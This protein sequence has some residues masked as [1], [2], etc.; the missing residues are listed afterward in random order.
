MYNIFSKFKK[1]NRTK[2]STTNI[3]RDILEEKIN[4]Y[5]NENSN[6]FLKTLQKHPVKNTEKN[7]PVQSSHGYRSVYFNEKIK[8][9][10]ESL[11][12]KKTPQEK[13]LLID[14]NRNNI[15][16]IM[17]DNNSNNINKDNQV[18]KN[19]KINHESNSYNNNYFNDPNQENPNANSI[20]SQINLQNIS[21][22]NKN[23]N[24]SHIKNNNSSRRNLTQND[25]LLK[26]IYPNEASEKMISESKKILET[27]KEIRSKISKILRSDNACPLCDNF[28]DKVD[29]F[30]RK[31][32]NS[33]KSEFT[34]NREK[35]KCSHFQYCQ[36]PKF[37]PEKE[38]YMSTQGIKEMKIPLEKLLRTNFTQEELDMI[39]YDLDFFN[40][41]NKTI[42]DIKFLKPKSLLK[43]IT[44]EEIEAE[45]DKRRREIAEKKLRNMGAYKFLKFFIN[46]KIAEF[47][48]KRKAQQSNQIQNQF[49]TEGSE[50]IN[51]ILNMKNNLN[52]KILSMIEL[53]NYNNNQV[54]RQK[55]VNNLLSDLDSKINSNKR[56]SFLMASNLPDY[57]KGFCN[58]TTN[59]VNLNTNNKPISGKNRP[60]ST[61][62]VTYDNFISTEAFTSKNFVMNKLIINKIKFVFTFLF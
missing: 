6:L 44:E 10:P 16:K 48:E 61:N 56:K 5:K 40:K 35:Q 8:L 24:Q 29:G 36:K 11:H 43:K 31:L 28:I 45:M 49:E 7:R 23:M 1:Q 20:K 38:F 17:H 39:K 54:N 32:V 47:R 12:A 21:A 19:N 50:N 2:S 27:K 25:L 51:K 15:N 53:N 59:N 60:L 13:V 26:T 14:T 4:V 62:K 18:I 55:F 57:K 34:L 9:I 3:R 52:K 58:S 22:V 41:N 33:L 30:N 42:N 46:Q 37:E